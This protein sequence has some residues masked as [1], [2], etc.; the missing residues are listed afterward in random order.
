M[1]RLKRL[2]Y[3]VEKQKA[4]QAE[5]RRKKRGKTE[6]DEEEHIGLLAVLGKEKGLPTKSFCDWKVFNKHRFH[7]ANEIPAK[8]S[9][10]DMFAVENMCPDTES[11]Q[12]SFA[13]VE[14]ESNEDNLSDW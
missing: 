2:K 11:D 14:S 9:A 12:I 7:H 5:Q 4:L 1:D 8:K 10:E 6:I 13:A 3:L